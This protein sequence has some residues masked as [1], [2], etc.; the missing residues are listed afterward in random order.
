MTGGRNL[1][2]DV[3]D[4]LLGVAAQTQASGELIDRLITGARTSQVP[5]RQ[6][7]LRTW[8]APLLVAAV[9]VIIAAGTLTAVALRNDRHPA[10]QPTPSIE[11]TQPNP[12]PVIPTTPA[13]L[14]PSLTPTGALSSAPSSNQA[15]GGSST[16]TTGPA[17]SST[18]STTAGGR[19]Q[20][21]VVRPVTANGKLAANFSVGAPAGNS[22]DC[23]TS[24]QASPA[25]VDDNILFCAPDSAYAIACWTASYQTGSLLC[26][27]FPW[28][29]TLTAVTVATPPPHAQAPATP[30]PLG[31][32]LDDGDH[33][34]LRDGGAWATR[35]DP[36]EYGTYSCTK[37]GAIWAP[38]GSDGITRSSS[39][40]RVHTG[41]ISGTGALTAHT[42]RT[43][44]FVGS[45]P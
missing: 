22:V 25:A 21:V 15:P 20:V 17:K 23:T 18:S 32:T 43:A 28:S 24:V 19:S 4:T 39:T 11:T 35:Q 30:R 34:L 1:E 14:K 10:E 29:T 3:H 41:P 12:A 8:L 27:Q 5:S 40:W 13:A 16:A 26:L 42:V 36:T 38:Q 2:S 31:L 9:V 7:H 6:S 45:A 44:Y 33:C 37:D